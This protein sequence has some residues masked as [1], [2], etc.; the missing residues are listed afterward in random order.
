LDKVSKARKSF[1]FVVFESEEAAEKAAAHPKQ[2][3]ADREVFFFVNF[4]NIRLFPAILGF[5]FSI[6][7]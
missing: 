2:N 7:M 3:F 6:F 1:A 4:G 5:S